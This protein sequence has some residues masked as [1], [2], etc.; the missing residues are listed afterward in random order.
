MCSKSKHTTSRL[1]PCAH[2]TTWQYPTYTCASNIS[3]GGRERAH[4]ANAA[5]RTYENIL[6]VP[7]AASRGGHACAAASPNYTHILHPSNSCGACVRSACRARWKA[8]K[9]YGYTPPASPSKQT[10][11]N[12]DQE[13]A[14]LTSNLTCPNLTLLE[15]TLKS[16]LKNKVCVNV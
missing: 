1:T 4:P 6:C 11:I 14:H 12:R 3:E 16:P 7:P 15:K 8:A 2:S 5:Q 10:E 13:R 9:R